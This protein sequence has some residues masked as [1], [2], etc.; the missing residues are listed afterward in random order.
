MPYE[1]FIYLGDSRNAPYGEKTVDEIVNLTVKNVEILFRQ[2]C[3]IIVI[4]CN[5]ATGAA[6][7]FLRN[8]YPEYDFV[9]LE[10]A[11]KPACLA[12][13]TGNIGVLATEGTFKAQHFRNTSE[14]YSEYIHI[15]SQPGYGLVDMVESD[16]I[17]TPEAEALLQK[18]ISP[19]LEKN[20]DFLVLGCT[21]FPFFKKT[22]Q[23]ICGD[24]VAILDSG[25]AVARRTKDI[26]M[27]KGLMKNLN[28]LGFIRI[29]TTGDVTTLQSVAGSYLE[30]NQANYSF[31][32]ID[33]L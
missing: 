7:H 1:D 33:R 27:T 29:I 15:H 5:T 8:T 32:H 6:I 26:L 31:S 2:K 21:H 19:L 18:Y 14:K 25:D 3:K 24:E 28:N 23:Q 4:A 12:S 17:N 22:I 11:V 30:I 9:G 10:P 13:K 20:I 16:M